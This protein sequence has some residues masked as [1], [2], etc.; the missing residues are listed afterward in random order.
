MFVVFVF[1]RY[2]KLFDPAS[3]LEIDP[4]N[5]RISTIAV[6]DR[7]SPY[8]KNNLYNAT[9]MASDNGRS[10]CVCMCIYMQK[11][12]RSSDSIDFCSREDLQLNRD[13]HMPT[14]PC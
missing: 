12:L 13:I 9:F 5:G 11:H 8:V 4:N 3:W 7:E 2:S 14:H 1:L 6:L 10:S